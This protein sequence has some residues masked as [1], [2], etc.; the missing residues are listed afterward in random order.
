MLVIIYFFKFQALFN[1]NNK[2]LKYP[3]CCITL[4]ASSRFTA[5]ASPLLLIILENNIWLIS[6]QFYHICDCSSFSRFS[7]QETANVIRLFQL[8]IKTITIMIGKVI[9]A[10][11]DLPEGQEIENKLFTFI[12]CQQR[13]LN[14]MLLIS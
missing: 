2:N 4:F 11:H 6:F 14:D 10:I 12:S 3:S 7:H 8:N 9:N 13:S 5:E 1:H